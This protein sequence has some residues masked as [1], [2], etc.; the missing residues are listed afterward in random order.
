M[1]NIETLWAY[2]DPIEYYTCDL[3]GKV[4]DVTF[5]DFKNKVVSETYIAFSVHICEDCLLFIRSTCIKTV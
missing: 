1:L 3:C 2:D 4:E 5:F